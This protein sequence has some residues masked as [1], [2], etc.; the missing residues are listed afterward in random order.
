[1]LSRI[2]QNGEEL[3]REEEKKFLRSRQ[4]YLDTP[5]H[6][7]LLKA[8]LMALRASII[9]TRQLCSPYILR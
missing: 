4:E 2:T 6:T 3:Y 1:M 9:V 5:F 7:I 8:M